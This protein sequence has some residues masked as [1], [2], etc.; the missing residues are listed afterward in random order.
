MRRQ[1]Q[2][3]DALRGLRGVIPINLQWTDEVHEREGVETVAA[4]T[5]DARR[6]TGLPARRKPI[7]PELFD[8][9]AAVASARGARH[10]GFFNADIVVSQAAIDAVARGGREAC[11]F[12]RMDIDPASGRELGL[13]LNGLDLFVFSVEFWQRERRR[14][15]P[16]IL[17]EWFYDCV[18]GA[19][20][21][22]H[23]DGEIFNRDGEIRHEAHPHAPQ[24]GLSVHNGY[25][26]ARDAHYFSLWV[27][28]RARLDAARSRGASA[29]EERAIQRDTFV[30]R[31]SVASALLQAGRSVRAYWRYQ[32]ERGRIGREAGRHDRGVL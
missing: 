15:R 6:I 26:A 10:F 19:V 16:Y 8:T 7:M 25:L 18:F 22:C 17:G 31:R 24:G 27:Q 20:L 12:S 30:L 29:E 5:Q 9:L 1:Q 21:M 32:R 11:A 2:A 23:G 4:L 3:L 13:V 14:F 28:Y